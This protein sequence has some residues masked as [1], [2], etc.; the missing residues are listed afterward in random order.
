MVILRILTVYAKKGTPRYIHFT[1]DGKTIATPEG[2]F[3]RLKRL[4]Q[5]TV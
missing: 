1:R 3:D 5:R 4:S 2:E